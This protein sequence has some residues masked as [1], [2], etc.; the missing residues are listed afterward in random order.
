MVKHISK[1]FVDHLL[2]TYVALRYVL[3]P[4]MGTVGHMYTDLMVVRVVVVVVDV[5]VVLVVVV[6]VS[7]VVVVVVVLVSVTVVVVVFVSVVVVVVVVAVLVVVICVMAAVVKVG[8]VSLIGSASVPLS[9][10]GPE[11]DSTPH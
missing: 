11:P 6:V 2:N 3:L 5:V 10:H 9:S 4:K 7:V 1:Q 8:T